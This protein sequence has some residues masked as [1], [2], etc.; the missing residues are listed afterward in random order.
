MWPVCIGN[1]LSITED[2]FEIFRDRAKIARQ[3]EE[4]Y[5]RREND[6]RRKKQI[7]KNTERNVKNLTTKTRHQRERSGTWSPT[8]NSDITKA[9]DQST[10]TTNQTNNNND[11]KFV[12][13]SSPSNTNSKHQTKPNQTKTKSSLDVILPGGKLMGRENT[14]NRIKVDLPRTFPQL[15][16]FVEGSPLHQALRDV[17]EAYTFMRPDCGYVQG[18]VVYFVIFFY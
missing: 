1:A 17:L 12:L 13:P 9:L 5:R 2:L 15:A 8:S 4:N 14:I 18:N 10:I 3:Q 11:N 16:F 6:I 7:E